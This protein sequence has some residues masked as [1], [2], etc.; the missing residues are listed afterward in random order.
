[1]L[2]WR[3]INMWIHPYLSL[4]I[5]IGETYCQRHPNFEIARVERDTFL[6]SWYCQRILFIF[7]LR[8]AWSES[9]EMWHGLRVWPSSC[10][11]SPFS[12]SCWAA[13]SK[14][15]TALGRSPS[16]NFRFPS[17]RGLTASL[18]G[19]SSVNLYSLNGSYDAEYSSSQECSPSLDIPC[20]RTRCNQTHNKPSP[21]RRVKLSSII[22]SVEDYQN[23]KID[24]FAKIFYWSICHLQ[25]SHFLTSSRNLVY[26]FQHFYLQAPILSW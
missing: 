10:Q 16:S 7:R 13:A 25:S 19:F 20:S 4:I 12:G 14:K 9:V 26:M 6:Q 2:N 8:G 15:R 11:A 21:A 23:H 1:M 18:T 17:S 3:N 22:I 5:L 24:L